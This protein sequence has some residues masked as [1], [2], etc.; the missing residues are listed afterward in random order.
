[1]E[2]GQPLAQQGLLA[3]VIQKKK[4]RLPYVFELR[5]TGVAARLK[6]RFQGVQAKSVTPGSVKG[7]ALDRG[8]A[9]GPAGGKLLM[10]L[11]RKLGN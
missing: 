6:A 7:K 5:A 4:S 1:M 10:N 11:Q 8:G 9:G 3:W 2:A